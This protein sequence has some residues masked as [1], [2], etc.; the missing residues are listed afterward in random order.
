MEQNSVMVENMG[1]QSTD[2]INQQ[3]TEISVSTTN[4]QRVLIPEISNLLT[5]FNELAVKNFE[6]GLKLGRESGNEIGMDK[7]LELRYCFKTT[8]LKKKPL[9]AFLSMAGFPYFT[10]FDPF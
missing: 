5:S 3:P 1:G 4:D 10:W 8:N 7:S 6:T 9:M 2:G